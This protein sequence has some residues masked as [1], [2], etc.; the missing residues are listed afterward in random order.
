MYKQI[1]ILK[2]KVGYAKKK[3]M[4]PKPE[5]VSVALTYFFSD[6][7]FFSSLFFSNWIKHQPNTFLWRVSK[8]VFPTGKNIALF[9]SFY[10]T[11]QTELGSRSDTHLKCAVRCSHAL[12]VTQVPRFHSS[13]LGLWCLIVFLPHVTPFCL[14]FFFLSLL[15]RKPTAGAQLW[16]RSSCQCPAD[17]VKGP[18]AAGSE[19]K[20]ITLKS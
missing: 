12:P 9:I 2:W 16:D 1:Q 20:T 13:K 17:E 18:C 11:Q 19:V 7:F 8:L 10:S 4:C 14:F 5:N 6:F 15:V 3:T